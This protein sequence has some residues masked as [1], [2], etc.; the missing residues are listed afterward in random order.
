MVTSD[1]NA[2]F[3]NKVIRVCLYLYQTRIGTGMSEKHIQEMPAFRLCNHLTLKFDRLLELA[4]N[5]SIS[6]DILHDFREDR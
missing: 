6:L 1:L 4:I 5:R 3:L 2:A